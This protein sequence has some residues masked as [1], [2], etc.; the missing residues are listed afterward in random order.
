MHAHGEWLVWNFNYDPPKLNEDDIQLSHMFPAFA[1]VYAVKVTNLGSQHFLKC[2]C[3]HY[4]RCGIPCL[5]ILKIVD[6]VDE[7]MVKIQHLKVF[8]VHYGKPECMLSSKLIEGTSIQSIYEEMG[9]PIS[10]RSLQRALNP[11]ESL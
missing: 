3:M 1:N 7:T 5:H 4:E 6:E 11:S 8:Q 10:E 2:D 9:M